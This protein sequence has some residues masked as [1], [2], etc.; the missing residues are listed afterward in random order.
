MDKALE[1]VQPLHLTMP[2]RRE[3]LGFGIQVYGRKA[4]HEGPYAGARLRMATQCLTSLS[5]EGKHEASK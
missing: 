1:L 2:I 4:I 5:V 3:R